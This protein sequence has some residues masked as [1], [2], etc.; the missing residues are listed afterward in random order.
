M[1]MTTIV[2]AGLQTITSVKSQCELRSIT[3][4]S[5]TSGLDAGTFHFIQS[6]RLGATDLRC[7]L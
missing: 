7:T 1:I 6:T 2:D 4:E 5:L 3:S